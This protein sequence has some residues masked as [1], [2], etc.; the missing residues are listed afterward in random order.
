MNT[1][2]VVGSV[3]HFNKLKK[4]Y[5][6]YSYK[7][8]KFDHEMW[9]GIDHFLPQ[10]YDLCALKTEQGKILK[11]WHTGQSWDGL[12]I[13]ERHKIKFWRRIYENDGPID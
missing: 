3:K 5:T 1:P 9:A 10:E 7:D 11:G 12:N 4:S 8:V 6:L 2:V 13:K